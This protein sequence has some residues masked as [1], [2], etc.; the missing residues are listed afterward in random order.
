MRKDERSHL[1]NAFDR[2]DVEPL[3]ASL[4]QRIYQDWQGVVAAN[5]K[6]SHRISEVLVMAKLHPKSVIFIAIITIVASVLLG[7]H[8]YASQDDE[9][10][11]I[12]VLSE[13]SL[14]TI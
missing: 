5:Q 6:P 14:S 3:A 2:I 9:L 4:E 12:D 1:K 8:F 11:R 7:Q 10:R 13:L